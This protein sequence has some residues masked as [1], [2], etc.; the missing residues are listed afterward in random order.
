MIPTEEGYYW[1]RPYSEKA[2]DEIGDSKFDIVYLV[3]KA[4]ICERCGQKF[5]IINI[6]VFP[7]GFSEDPDDS[8]IFKIED[9]TD[10]VGPLEEPK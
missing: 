6:R 4:N 10:W 7:F 2:I 5:G 9:F 3:M 1:A 8:I